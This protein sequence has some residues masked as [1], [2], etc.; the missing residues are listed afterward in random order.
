MKTFCRH[1]LITLNLLMMNKSHCQRDWRDFTVDLGG[2][3]DHK[4]P[5]LV[6][7]DAMKITERPSNEPSSQPSIS[8]KPSNMPTTTPTNLPSSQPSNFPSIRPTTNPSAYPTDTFRPSSFPTMIPT[9]NP[10]HDKPSSSFSYNPYAKYGPKNW[11]R[12]NVGNNEY[13]EF[14][15][16]NVSKN[17]CD[18]GGQSPIDLHHN[19]KCVEHHQIRTRVSKLLLII[20]STN[21]FAYLLIS[22]LFVN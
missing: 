1:L 21:L 9:F 16:I 4:F 19:A 12:V 22:L 15:K 14:Q 5:G 2:V 8:L 6:E 11:D 3:D 10:T 17:Q 20:F 13:K 7:K 18:S